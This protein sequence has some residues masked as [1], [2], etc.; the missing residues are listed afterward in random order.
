M[1][2]PST[3][4]DALAEI[5][6]LRGQVRD[7]LRLL[8]ESAEPGA[9]GASVSPAKTTEAYEFSEGLVPKQAEKGAA[10]H[11]FDLHQMIETV[12][13]IIFT[14]DLQGDLVGWN[15]R[16]QTVTG[17][18]PQ[19]LT[20]RSALAFVPEH[21]H[22]QTAAAIQ[23]AFAEGYAE[24]EGHLLTKDGRTIP[25]QWTGAALKDPQ[26][27]VI[28]I[29]GV[30]RDITERKQAEDVLQQSEAHFRALIEHS[31]DIITVLDLDGTVRFESPSFERLLGYQ[32]HEI[33]GLVAFDFIHPDD[34]PAVLQ[35]FQLVV[36]RPGEPQTAE[37]R[38]RHKDGSW[39]VLE[40]I[41]RSILDTEGRRCVIVNSRDIT[42]RRRTQEA[43][44]RS[45]DLLK[46][47]VEHTPGAVAMLDKNLRYVAV[48]RRWIQDYRLDEQD[49]IGR[50]H[51]DIFPEI[52]SNEEWQA[53]HRRCLNGAMERREEDRFVRADGSEDW[54]K[55]EVRPW[56]DVTGNIGGIIMFTDV[57]TERK[58]AEQALRLSEER[59]ARATAIG[60]VGVWELDGVTG[61]YH[62]DINLSA[63]FGYGPD[64]LSTDPYEWLGLVHPQDQ[65]IALKA[66]ES[67]VSGSTNDYHYELR[68]IRK[69]GTIIWTDVRG[70][71]ER[72]EHGHVQRLIGATVDITERKRAEEFLELENQI[73][74]RVAEG[75]PLTT[76]I[77]QLC[78]GIEAIALDCLCSTLLLDKDGLHLR[79]IAGPS[80]PVSYTAA[81]DGVAIGPSVGSCGTAAY[82]KTLTVV[83]DIATDPLWADYKDLALHHGL[84][85]CWSMPII[86][87]TDSVLGTFAVYYRVPRHPTN[88][89]IRLIEQA[90]RLAQMAI[91]RKHAEQALKASEEKLKQSLLASNTG[92]WDWNTETNEVWL[93]REWKGQ[94]GYEEAEVPNTFESWE[95]KLHPDDH[96]RAVA[97]TLQYREN[98]IGV[99][100]QDFRLRHKDGTYRWIDSQA[101]FVKEADGRRVRLLGSHTDITD[102]K[103]AE[104][105]LSESEARFRTLV[106]NIPGAIYRCAVDTEWTMSYLSHAIEEIVGYPAAEFIGNHTRSYAS[107]IHP[108]DRQLVED[109]TGASLR[110]RRPYV[111]EYR[112]IHANGTVRWVY[113]KGQGVFTPDGE[114]RFLDGAIFDITERKQADEALRRSET[115]LKEAQRIAHIGSWD[116]DLTLNRLIWSDEVYRIF[117][118]DRDQ[119][120]GSYEAFLALV[121]PEDRAAVDQ[122]YTQSIRL[123]TPYAITHRLLMADGRVKYVQERCETFYD[124]TGAPLRS[125]GTVQ[126]VTE[127]TR[128]AQREATRLRQLQT[129]SELGLTLS[130]DPAEIFERVVRMLGELFQVRAVCLS[131]IIGETLHFKAIYYNGVVVRERGHCRLNISPCATVQR[132]KEVH[133]F[134]RVMEQFPEA[135]FL[136]DH[137]AVSYCGFPALDAQGEVMA[138]TCLLDDKPREYTAEDQALLK[139]FGQRIAIEIERA[140]YLAEQRRQSEALRRSHTFLRQVIDTAPNFI[141]AKDRGGRFLLANKAVAEAYGTTVDGLIGKTDIDFNPNRDE[142]EFFTKKDFEVLDS[143]EERFI[144]EEKFTD[145]AGRVRWL[146]TVKRPL[147][148]DTGKVIMVLGASTDITARKEMEL[149][150]RRR[151]YDLRVAIAERER[152]SEDLHDGILQSIYAVGLGLEACKPLIAK[153]PKRSAVK[154]KTELQRTI[155][156]LNHVLEEVRNFI[157]GLESHILDGQEFDAVLRTMVQTLASSYSVPCRVTVEKAAAQRL[158]TEQAYHVMNVAREALSNSFRHSHARK[159]ALSFKCLRRSV[160][161]SVVDDGVGFNPS[162]VRDTGHG[163][164]NMDSRASKIGGTFTLL[165]KPRGGTRIIL[166]LPMRWTDA[167]D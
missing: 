121:H 40:G 97:Y 103:Q 64:E 139:V 19:E 3:L 65:A 138:I 89:E 47:F 44:A 125:V 45:Y 129:L 16:L 9:A 154:L 86:S 137:Q 53:V 152:I 132:D 166:D 61:L 22:A 35:K 93:S 72:D 79:H 104:Q 15:K 2:A 157:A 126:D 162:A 55:W 23:R 107:V 50:H 83:E 142:V 43:L 34:L 12:P 78:I 123:K 122:A 101:S 100:R 150:L 131:E 108:D 67:I 28:G 58:R 21:E 159:I 119:F 127:A 117:E 161:L 85:S 88:E 120:G 60:K 33:D 105:T 106:A 98:P 51:Y 5:E 144:P 71:A 135:S 42:E 11:L 151:E 113:E 6:A 141:F 167:D 13:D 20:G 164:A 17:F 82:L 62:G 77:D 95:S 30:G 49:L 90:A 149:A 1:K 70:H 146:Q 46:S 80:L 130:G 153:Q 8:G 32:Q 27:D 87:P 7:L 160:R 111:L 26:G 59:Y 143:L 39:L 109:A 163:L 145:A 158:S 63:L 25:Y 18:T 92:L 96:A 110:E 68:M 29:T 116:L 76:I 54:L 147:L 84:R 52:R 115:R 99:F 91:E 155:G 94:L 4:P 124:A 136:H 128:I 118:H 41:G 69:D 24:L 38:F 140:R 31:S 48:S 10:Q 134:D 148:D 102:R 56:E 57:I 75:M 165:S 36:Q 74:E 81:I 14:L 37:F 133:L 73:L 66:W 112:L 114:V 156:Q